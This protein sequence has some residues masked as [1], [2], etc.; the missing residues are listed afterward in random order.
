MH[1]FIVIAIALSLSGHSLAI[2]AKPNAAE[3]LLKNTD[4][5]ETG[6]SFYSGDWAKALE[7]SKKDKKLIFLDAYASWCGPCKRMAMTTFTDSTVGAYFNENFISYKMDMEK[8]AE[9]PRLSQKFLLEAYP[10]LYFIN[11]DESVV[12]Y[13]VG[14]M[15]PAG[16]IAAGKEAK[17]KK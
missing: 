14:F 5:V 11:S 8:H 2:Q 3:F 7:K 15:D 6:I 4:A 12:H 17:G 9:G 16:L 1:K 13:T 10:T